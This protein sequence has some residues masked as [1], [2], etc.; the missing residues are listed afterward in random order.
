MVAGLRRMHNGKAPGPDKLPIEAWKALG[1]EGVNIL[2][3][4]M[5]KIFNGEKMPNIWRQ[6]IL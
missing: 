6:S 4:L 3:E 2:C 5:N 1:D